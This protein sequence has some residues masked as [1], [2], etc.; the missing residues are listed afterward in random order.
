MLFLL[1]AAIKELKIQK[2]SKKYGE[3]YNRNT[4]QY[5]Y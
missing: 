3:G 4:K 1:V 2:T 5:E